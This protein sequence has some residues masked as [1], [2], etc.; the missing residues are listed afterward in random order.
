MAASGSA[1]MSRRDVLQVG[2]L[3]DPFGS[4][5]KEK[6]LVSGSYRQFSPVQACFRHAGV[7]RK[8][9]VRR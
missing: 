2:A 9:H 3:Y 8:H 7:G 5:V 6:T 1:Q 4:Q